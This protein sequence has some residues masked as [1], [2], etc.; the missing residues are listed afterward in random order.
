MSIAFRTYSNVKCKLFIA[1]IIILMKIINVL[2]FIVQSCMQ[3]CETVTWIK[4]N[5]K[6]YSAMIG[7]TFQSVPRKCLYKF[8]RGKELSSKMWRI[9]E[10][11][12]IYLTKIKK[13]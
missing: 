3:M 10:M 12:L 6:L 7:H 13:W 11:L 9:Y 1:D 2:E 5:D 4:P 8:R